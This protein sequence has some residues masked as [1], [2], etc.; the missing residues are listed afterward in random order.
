MKFRGDNCN[1]TE[2][3]IT[4]MK[5]LAVSLQ[6]GDDNTTIV[7]FDAKGSLME[8]EFI[9]RHKFYTGIP[10]A[11]EKELLYTQDPFCETYRIAYYLV[12]EG[13]LVHCEST[14]QIL[15]NGKNTCRTEMFGFV[16]GLF[17]SMN[18]AEAL[19]NASFENY[20]L[21]YNEAAKVSV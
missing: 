15:S 20:Y 17:N 7:T 12:V 10:E 3:K 8:R 6:S 11:L 21:D 18:F 19:R 16:K 2:F 9:V 4:N 14:R 13:H 1:R 5:N